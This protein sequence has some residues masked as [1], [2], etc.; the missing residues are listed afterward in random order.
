MRFEEPLGTTNFD[1]GSRRLGETLQQVETG[2]SERKLSGTVPDMLFIIVAIFG[3][4]GSQ[5]CPTPSR[6]LVQ[7]WVIATAGEVSSP[8]NRREA[9]N[10][11]RMFTAIVVPSYTGTTDVAVI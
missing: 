5:G 2:G 4:C 6:P 1:K 7:Q 10:F 8:N 11:E 9:T 3:Q